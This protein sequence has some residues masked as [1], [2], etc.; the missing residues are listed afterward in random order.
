MTVIAVILF[1]GGDAGG[2]VITDHG[3]KPIPPF[4]PGI[5][6]NLRAANSMLKAAAAVGKDALRAKLT[7]SAA[8][9]ANIAVEQIEEAIGPLGANASVV[10]ADDDGGFTCGS[11]GKPPIPFPWPVRSIPSAQ[12]YVTAGVVGADLVE[13]VR[14][15]RAKKISLTKL[16]AN[17][18]DVA[19]ELGLHLSAK[20]AAE[21]RGLAADNLEAIKNPVEKEV[22]GFFQ[23]VAE[24]GRYLDEWFTRPYEVS[25]TLGMK[26]SDAASELILTG[27][28]GGV[29]GPVAD[30]A[31]S[32]AIAAGI[33]VGV[34]IA[35]GTATHQYGDYARPIETFVIDRS[36]KAKI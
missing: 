35:V 15:A 25:K 3:I 16:F 30:D 34:C 27:S 5:L 28:A 23:K 14:T 1:G 6:L 17:P 31:G 4:D 33:W 10:Y 7:K 9:V 24:D 32:Y 11:T 19:R 22:V 36:A 8:S 26:L 18:E 12:T 20:S 21:L 13:V 2:L 29:L